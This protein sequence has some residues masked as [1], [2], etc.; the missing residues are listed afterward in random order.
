MLNILFITGT[1]ADY[2]LLKP[3]VNAVQ[4]NKYFNVKFLVTGMHTM[5]KFGNTQV[6]IKRGEIPIAATVAISEKDSMLQSLNKEISGITQYCKKNQVDLMVVLGDR[7][8][9]LAGAIV[10]SHL[11]IPIAHIHGGDVAGKVVDDATRNAI[12]KL[13]H[14][15]LAASKKSYNR[16]LKMGEE[17][18]RVF[19]VGAPGLD[20]ISSIKLKTKKELSKI[21]N[22]NPNKKWFIVVH[23]PTP[24]DPTPT[25]KQIQPLLRAITKYDAEILIGYPNSDTGNDIFISEI[26][27]Y[28]KRKNV[29][30]FR[31]TT[32]ELFLSLL[33]ICDLMIGNSSS[34]VIESTSFRIPT[35]NVGHRQ[36]GR[37]RGGNV[38]DCD[39]SEQSIKGAV[40][41]TQTVHFMRRVNRAKTPYGVGNASKNIA[42]IL[43]KHIK[44]FNIN[45]EKLFFKKPPV[46]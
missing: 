5:K 24:L 22:A 40:A 44:L 10:G 4:Q 27:K 21:F 17:K 25:R 46:I 20:Q 11:K 33:K 23:H 16:V 36:D 15:H 8:E 29:H 34:G 28:R 31:T 35:I 6:E 38:I 13:S 39:Y 42:R 14:F 9:M 1:R 3:V 7:D 43:A 30:I 37:E 32:R 18:W 45:K 26:E 2:G 19:L 41:C 12:T